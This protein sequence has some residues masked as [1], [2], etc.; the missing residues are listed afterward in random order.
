MSAGAGSQ[1]GHGGSGATA[2]GPAG[3]PR[4]DSPGAWGLLALLVAG[5]IGVY[6]CRKNL[7]VAVPLLVEDF[8][9]T[10]EEVGRIA[11]VGTL[12]Y[13]AGKLLLAP[14]VD[15]F[16]G[17]DSFLGALLAVVAC[18]ALSGL[19]PSLGILGLAYACN[20]LGASPAWAAMVKQASPWFGSRSQAFALGV[21]SLSYV[22][23][24]AA[25][26]A[27]AGW[28]AQASGGSWRAILF[29]PSI[30]LAV[31]A[32][33]A[34]RFL[35]RDAAPRRAAGTPGGAPP[36]ARRAWAELFRDRGFQVLCALSFLLTL[37][38][39]T[40]NDWT[41]D[42]LKSTGGPDVSLRAASFLS[43]P[44][45]LCGAAGI[46]V[47]GVLLGR[48]SPA[49]QRWVLAVTLALLAGSLVLL[50]RPAQLPLPWLVAL[51]GVI[52]FCGLGPYSLLAGY[53]SVRLRGPAL[54]GTVSGLI[55][56]AGYLAG[57]LAGSGFGWI[58]DH[59]GYGTGF[60]LLAGGAAAAAGLALLLPASAPPSDHA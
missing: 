1:A 9:A 30:V 35:P 18:G 28:V 23:G 29:V 13:A 5:Y 20:R 2:A 44:F 10:R 56:S 12:A 49:R 48:W 22:F 14:L 17:R 16:G 31:L 4:P 38:R 45:D 25:A 15:R 6:L 32:L 39:E 42:F 46:L 54:A 34:W 21:L 57:V 3:A 59:W 60:G 7:A 55:D 19:S 40:F 51:L 8:G 52:G 33:A 53:Y 36:P 50:S 58:L 47:L 11:S 26:V 41:V 37:V 27:L 43:L 24:G